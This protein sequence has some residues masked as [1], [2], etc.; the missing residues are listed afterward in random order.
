[1][2]FCGR[3]A[4]SFSVHRGPDLVDLGG[5]RNASPPALRS[6]GERYGL[7]VDPHS[8]RGLLQRFDLRLGE[9]I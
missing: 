7:E 2:L 6:L 5:S 1:M 4:T 8:I 9:A 3:R